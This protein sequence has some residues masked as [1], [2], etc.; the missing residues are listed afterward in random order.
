MFQKKNNK[1]TTNCWKIA[2][3]I[4][5][6]IESC[7]TH[8]FCQDSS[9][10][11]LGQFCFIHF[12][13][14]PCVFS[15]NCAVVC[16]TCVCLC[17]CVS[18]CVGVKASFQHLL[19]IFSAA[20]FRFWC[21]MESTKVREMRPFL[22]DGQQRSTG[23][24]LYQVVSKYSVTLLVQEQSHLAILHWEGQKNWLVWHCLKSTTHVCC[25]T[26]W[27]W[28]LTEYF[29]TTS[30]CW[31][32]VPWDSFDISE[33]ICSGTRKGEEAMFCESNL[34][35]GVSTGVCPDPLSGYARR[36]LCFLYIVILLF[37][38]WVVMTW[39]VSP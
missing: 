16:Q 2:K 18:F 9:L 29:D 7:T 4:H 36:N 3:A 32:F 22:P 12:L 6:A 38:I 34:A 17:V 8:W 20:F 13:L 23:M 5:P 14:H 30:Y 11:P 21:T 33:F 19:N 35:A 39:F 24:C 28:R 31:Q 27:T 10:C 25:Q 15:E 1:H 37:V 26:P